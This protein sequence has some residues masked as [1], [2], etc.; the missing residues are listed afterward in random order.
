MKITNEVGLGASRWWVRRLKAGQTSQP[1][2]RCAHRKGHA[3]PG[4][5]GQGQ[6]SLPHAWWCRRGR[7]APKGNKNALNHGFYIRAPWYKAQRD[8][9]SAARP[10]GRF[11]RSGR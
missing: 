8:R 5:G 10:R 7:G 3:A 11:L 4:A 2:V 1:A 9:W 6:A